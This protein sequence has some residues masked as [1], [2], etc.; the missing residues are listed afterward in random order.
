[1]VLLSEGFKNKFSS[2]AK[3]YLSDNKVTVIPNAL[4]FNEFADAADLF[5]KK[6]RVLIVS[7][8]DEVQKRISLSIAI[9]REIMQDSKYRNWSLE[10]VGNR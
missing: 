8:L 3:V 9:W 2:Y 6:K 4:S 7:R 1:M 5:K 10:I